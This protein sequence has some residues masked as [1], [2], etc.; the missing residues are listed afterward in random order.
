M[1]KIIFLAICIVVVVGLV[2]FGLF[3]TKK[4]RAPVP[5]TG[6]ISYTNASADLI[7]IELPFPGAV[8]GKSFSVIGKA[9]GP[10][11]FEASFPV[12]VLDKNGTRLAS[13]IAQAQGDWM[14][15]DFVGFK[16]DIVV[17]D[18]YIGPA[19]LLLRKDNASGLPEHDAS[20]SFPITIEY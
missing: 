9:R 14:T 13:G 11:F 15:P 6:N 3:W 18:S 12:E 1:K 4:A 16:A 5:E 17:P 7:T 2:W 10:W 20:V 8:T 19:T